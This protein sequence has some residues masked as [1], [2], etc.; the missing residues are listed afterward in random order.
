MSAEGRPA[1]PRIA[2]VTGG[3]RGIGRAIVGQLCRAGVEVCF[4]YL[5]DERA[6]SSVVETLQTEGHAV[7]AARVDSRD[8]T[9]LSAFVEGVVTEHHR[10]DVLI[11]NAG[12]TADRLLHVMSDEEWQVVLDTSLKGLF[13]A[14][15]IAARQMMR[16]RAGRIVSLTSVSALSGIAGQTNYAAA[17][18]AIIG[19][20][21]AL[22]RELGPW[23]V[24]VNAVAPGYVDTEML[25]SLTPAQRKAA[26]ERVPL[27][28]FSSPDEIAELVVYMALQAPSFLT[29]QTIAIDGGMTA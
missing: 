20:T 24:C 27:R 9:A 23:S 29:G 10:L 21:R 12:V 4:T 28:R 13:G 16:Q 18:A 25:D 2:I 7:R 26:L 17:K 8:A 1:D 11:N 5:R 19:F 22:A 6:A 15:R 14:T 3:S